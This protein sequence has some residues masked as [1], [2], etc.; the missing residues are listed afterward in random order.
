MTEF[1]GSLQPGNQEDVLAIIGIE[2]LSIDKRLE[3]LEDY[4][5]VGQLKTCRSLLEEQVLL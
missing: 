5:T 3:F 4:L 2:N 1:I